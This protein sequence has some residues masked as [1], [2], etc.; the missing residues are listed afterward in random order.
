MKQMPLLV[1]DV[2]E[3]AGALRS[4]GERIAATQG[5]TQAR[6]QVMSVITD[7]ELSVPR[8]ARRLGVSRQNVQRIANELDQAGL[9]RW[10]DNPDHRSSPLLILTAQGRHALDAITTQARTFNAAIARGITEAQ[11][12]N[13]REVLATITEHVHAHEQHGR[14]Q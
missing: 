9:T 13:V 12:N 8:I 2:Y 11:I 6:W 10:Q 4:A 7:D 3:L 5:Q 14:A 1:A